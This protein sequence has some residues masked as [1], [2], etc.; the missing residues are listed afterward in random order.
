MLG[1]QLMKRAALGFKNLLLMLFVT[2]KGSTSSLPREV[3]RKELLSTFVLDRKDVVKKSNTIR[4][5]RLMPRRRGKEPEGRLET[6]VCRST[7][8]TEARVWEICSEH[9]DR[10]AGKSAIGRG[11][12][13]AEVVYAV[14]LGFDADGKPYPE[15]ANIIGWHDVSNVPD[16]ELKHHWMDQAQ[17][18]A[19]HFAYMARR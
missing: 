14:G 4:H 5:S 19:S 11:V 10:H 1:S 15:H 9:F 8:L 17:K 6:S 13:S 16:S 12:G 7:H 18:M 3:P 2:Y